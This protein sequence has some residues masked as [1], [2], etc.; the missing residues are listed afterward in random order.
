RRGGN[1]G[2]EGQEHGEGRRSVLASSGHGLTLRI[3]SERANLADFGPDKGKDRN[4]SLIF[5]SF[6]LFFDPSS[7]FS[8]L[9][10]FLQTFPLF[11]KRSSYFTNVLLIRGR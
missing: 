4:V 7:F 5:G 9:S 1:G 3:G 6:L 2:R 11:Y 10:L 8:R